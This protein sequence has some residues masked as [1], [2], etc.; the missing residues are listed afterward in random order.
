M[1]V[2]ESKKVLRRAMSRAIEDVDFKTFD[3]LAAKIDVPNFEL[4]PYKT[5]GFKLLM[6]HWFDEIK[7]TPKCVCLQQNYAEKC[8]RQFQ[9]IARKHKILRLQ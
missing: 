1:A 2:N 5:E 4:L 7:L 6:W 8:Y 9:A 3:S